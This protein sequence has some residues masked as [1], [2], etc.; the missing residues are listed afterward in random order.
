MG[1]WSKLG[2]IGM[3][4][5]AGAATIGTMGAASPALAAALGSVGIGSK[6]LGGI[7]AASNAAKALSPALSGAAK[8]RAEGRVLDTNAQ[9]AQDRLGL[10]RNQQ[11]NQALQQEFTNKLGLHKTEADLLSQ[12]AD[13][14]RRGDLQA[15]VQDVVIPDNGRVKVA[16]WQGG[17]RPSAMGP[18]AR[19]AGAQ[20]SNSAM[21]AMGNENLPTAPMLSAGVPGV[22]PLA[23]GAGGGG[24]LMDKILAGASMGTGILG[25]LPA[26]IQK[27]KQPPYPMDER[28]WAEGV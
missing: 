2:K 3:I 10:D 8:G 6:V 18:N 15:N 22:T 19:A 21:S 26:G 4:A 13:Q 27:P 16:H 20:L 12:R 11:L 9:Q 24:G 14:T 1:F 25:S 28:Q 17:V 23:G 7:G 5:G